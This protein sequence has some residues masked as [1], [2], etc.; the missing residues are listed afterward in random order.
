[1]TASAPW[2]RAPRRLVRQPRL[3]AA[4]LLVAAVVGL[5][6]ATPL[7]FLSSV[8][9][10][11]IA[12]QLD[13][14]CRGTSIDPSMRTG[15]DVTPVELAAGQV[16]GFDPIIRTIVLA[17]G[18]THPLEVSTATGS[19]P[20]V[21]GTRTG[22][23]DHLRPIGPTVPGDG[24]WV[25]DDVATALDLH[26][27][28]EVAIGV[29]DNRS[30]V[31]VVGVYP[32]LV[33]HGYDGYWCSLRP[34]LGTGTTFSDSAPP[35]LVLTDASTLAGL[36]A[37][38]ALNQRAATVE[39]PLSSRP[40]TLSAAQLAVKRLDRLEAAVPDFNNGTGVVNPTANTR[41]RYA[42]KRAAAIRAS[43]AGA[44][45]PMAVV[46]ALVA[47]GLV[48]GVTGSWLDR[49]RTEVRLLWVRGVPAP[50]IGLKAVLE[51]LVPVALGLL[52][53]YGFAVLAIPWLGP[54]R[55]LD[56]GVVGWAGLWVLAGF[57]AALVAVLLTVVLRLRQ[58]LERI[59]RRRSPVPLLWEVPVLLLA[60]W[61]LHRFN[62]KGLPTVEGDALPPI[63]VLSLLF[64]LLF[65]AGGLGLAAR[66]LRLTLG[67]T[68]RLG[69]RW[70][71]TWYLAV[72]RLAA[73]RDAVL[74]LA[75]LAAMAVGVV[76]YGSGLVRS[77]NATVRAKAG[78][79]LGADVAVRFATPGIPPALVGR[80]T[81]ARTGREGDYGGARVHLLMVDP[82]TFADGAYWNDDFAD[83]P[84]ATLLQELAAP[85]ADGSVPAIAVNGNLAPSGTF[86]ASDLGAPQ[87]ELR[88]VDRV[89][90]FPG[91]GPVQPTLVVAEGRAPALEDGMDLQVWTRGTGDEV[92][93]AAADAGRSIVFLVDAKQ[94]TDTSPALPIVWTFSFVQG[95]G[96][97]VGLLAVVGL[98]AYVDA[99]QRQRSVAT[100]LL[101]RMGL[102]AGR[103]WRSLALELAVLA[104]VAVLL[105]TVLGWVAV[106]AVNSHLDPIP[107]R[108]PAPLLRFPWPAVAGVVGA[109]VAT[110]LAGSGLAQLAARRVNLGEALREDV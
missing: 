103:Q 55:Y 10:G 16:G 59:G 84:L 86:V 76:V 7:L 8:A 69:R 72:R 21:I 28:D 9:S 33:Q 78:V 3:A 42:T 95:L 15:G 39:L 54:S 92:R 71:M 23:V 110:V 27:G 56:P 45:A 82:A 68:R 14:L 97:M 25:P 49:R 1:M 74:V 98:V 41:L 100:S 35:P 26:A 91:M 61:S 22:Y 85:T 57:A 12:H 20:V 108:L 31:R 32:S 58:G 70:P 62:E 77:T 2:R 87:G 64:P 6:A 94:L 34:Y 109:A 13:P 67:L 106:G 83:R 107:D 79:E 88:V 93:R 75:G 63:D 44:V 37:R 66:L 4:A 18:F 99:R 46:S 24:I 73:E 96:V 51:L 36:R 11:A 52:A 5:V 19:R 48:C 65:L 30:S 101:G 17:G 90:T 89:T 104:A 102:P 105:G 50:L 43:V 80:A 29:Q 40:R 53:G 81:I 60:A 38:Y 47:L